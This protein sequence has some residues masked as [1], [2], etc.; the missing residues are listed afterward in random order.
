MADAKALATQGKAKEVLAKYQEAW[1]IIPDA[2]LG[3]KIES[4]KK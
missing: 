4:L 1:E 3:T 2:E